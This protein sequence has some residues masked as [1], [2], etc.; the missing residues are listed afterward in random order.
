[1]F[2]KLLIANRGEIACR[3]MRTCEM[4][5]I[6]TV[7]VYSEA[8][9]EAQHVQMADEAYLLGGAAPRDSY[10]K[11]D[12]IIEVGLQ[13]G[14]EA[15]HPG[16]GFLSESAAFAQRCQDAGFRFVG[17][18]PQVIE[19]MGDKLQARKM[20]KRAGV[21]V[22]PG[23]SKAIDD[24]HATDM[25]WSLGF[26]L[27]VKATGGGGGIGI[28]IIQSLAE[29]E[30]VVQQ[31][32]ALAAS[33]FGS[34]TLYFERFMEGASHIEVQVLGD[35][36]GNLVHLMAR[37]CSIQR[38]NQKIVEESP[39]AKLTDQQ[40]QRLWNYAV[41]FAKHVG[42][43][44]AGT[45]EFLVSPD[46]G[47]FFLEMNTRLQ[48]EHGVTEMITGLDL[49]ELQLRVA[50]G[51]KLPIEQEDVRC[52]GHAIEARIYPEDP[53]TLFPVAGLIDSY[54]VP[55]G[56]HVRVDS[57]LCP[58]YEVTTHYES[59]IAKLICWGENRE[60]ARKRL[61]EALRVFRLEGIKCNIPLLRRV[62]SHPTFINSAYHTDFLASIGT[63]SG[64]NHESNG[65]SSNGDHD[66][67]LASAIGTALL[68]SMSKRAML[69]HDFSERGAG[70]WKMAGRR[71]QAMNR[72]LGSR[73]WR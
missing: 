58:N 13:S 54:H 20:A 64:S 14:A 24:A 72:A 22:L 34:S 25:A 60:E 32:R 43:T 44:N 15:V 6:K 26:P 47:M 33:A 52:S 30:S 28:K 55:T 16:Y 4:I 9:A 62:V 27:M 50:A 8:D 38:R 18:S 19:K 40:R 45:I 35:E 21:P 49:V 56:K 37:D 42:Y 61:L 36:H 17:P 46:G 10:L 51:E 65:V 59:I 39:A 23:S 41:R 31:Q 48:V 70:A 57:A 12:K 29:L 63:S 11:M 67:E 73:T 5:G 66:K 1:M 71:G 2:R 53:E 3:I 7:A 69:G 68:I